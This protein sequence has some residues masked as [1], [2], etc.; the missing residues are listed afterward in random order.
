MLDYKIHNRE[1]DQE[2]LV[3]IHG[4]GGNSSIF[5]KQ[6]KHYK[7]EFNVITIELPGH[8]KSPDLHTYME[9]F[10]YQVA[11][12]EVLTTLNSL[13]IKQAHFV[14]VSLGTIIIH[15]LLQDAPERVKSAV[16]AGTVTRFTPFSKGLLL[17]GKAIKDFTPY[18]WIYRLFARIMMPKSNHKQSRIIF[19]KEAIKMKRSN[20]LG[21][22]DTC[23]SVEESYKDV[24]RIASGIPKLY[25]SGSEDHLFIGPLKEDIENDPNATL[26]VIEKCGHVCNL[27]RAKEF[28]DL[29]L[30]FLLEQQEPM[31][32]AN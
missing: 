26:V 4:L 20:F 13:G 19:I 14:G 23:Y 16:L 24:Q 2:D 3:L 21:W 7:K 10:S 18:I 9:E 1:K 17:L 22:Y 8:G 28:N 32:Q 12:R 30:T 27:E 31:K 6:F 29:S 15:Y 5:Y 25:V 11:A